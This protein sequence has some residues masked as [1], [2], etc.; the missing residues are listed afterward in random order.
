MLLDSDNDNDLL[1][2][3]MLLRLI[4]IVRVLLMLPLF[5]V[6]GC[7]DNENTPSGP[8]ILHDGEI[9]ITNDAEVNIRL[10]EFTQI[11]GDLEYHGDMNIRVYSDMRYSLR[12][13]LDPGESTVFPGGDQVSV[14]FI[15]DAPDP[16]DPELPLFENT[17]NLTVD[18]NTV[19]VVKSG[20]DYSMGPG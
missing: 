5:G 16:G 9:T 12:N 8:I 6:S 11:R 4:V 7:S 20:G 1:I 19:I 17:V 3:G 18:G 15:A 10:R 13:R 14:R 2:T